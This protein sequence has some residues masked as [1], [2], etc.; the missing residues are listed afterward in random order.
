MADPTITFEEHI[1]P[2]FTDYLVGMSGIL[3][4]SD[5][6]TVKDNNEAITERIHGHERNAQGEPKHRHPMPPDHALS[7]RKLDLWKKWIDGG[8]IQG[9]K[10][11]VTV[12]DVV[13][14]EEHIKI[15]F[16]DYRAKMLEVVISA[17]GQAVVLD[18][19]DYELVKNQ[20][21]RISIALHGYE[22]AHPAT[23]PMPPGNQLAPGNLAI[24]DKWVATGMLKGPN[25]A[26]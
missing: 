5:Y 18:L 2:L 26:V 8:M 19:W 17:P 20:N 15:I 16:E 14:F 10:Q 24:W 12:P 3:D 9:I 6:D 22:A 25:S 11:Q 21:K 1:K 23:N 7:Q 4:L 13:I